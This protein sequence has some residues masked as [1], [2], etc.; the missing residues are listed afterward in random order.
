MTKQMVKQTIA[1]L[2]RN[3]GNTSWV[4]TFDEHDWEQ[5]IRQEPVIDTDFNEWLGSEYLM[6]DTDRSYMRCN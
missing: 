4:S 2:Y 1:Q 5:L 3:Q 6:E